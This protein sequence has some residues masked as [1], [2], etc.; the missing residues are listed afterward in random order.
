MEEQKL[1][2][3]KRCK[4]YLESFPKAKKIVFI[5]KDSY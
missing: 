3:I 1:K 5:A 2:L 4:E